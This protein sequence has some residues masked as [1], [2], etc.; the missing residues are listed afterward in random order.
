MKTQTFLLWS[1]RQRIWMLAA[2]ALVAAYSGS[3]IAADRIEGSVNGSGGP[4]GGAMVT[5]WAAGEAAPRKLAETQTGTDGYF[6][7]PV[8]GND[9]NEVLYNGTVVFFGVAKPVRTP[10]FAR[11]LRRRRRNCV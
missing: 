11:K 4:I 5:L 8:R 2:I 6:D 1:T 7:M 9:R 3:A 10:R